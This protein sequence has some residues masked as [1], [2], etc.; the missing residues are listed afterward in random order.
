VGV[1]GELDRR[2][3]AEHATGRFAVATMID[4]YVDVYRDVI[5]SRK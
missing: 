4:K 3:I 2:R 1:A 5:G